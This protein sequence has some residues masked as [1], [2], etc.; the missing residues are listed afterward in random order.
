MIIAVV[1]LAV[2][3]LFICMT[4]IKPAKLRITLSLLCA[5]VVIAS[6]VL[7]VKNDRE[8]FGLQRVSQT[9]TYS[10]VSTASSAN[11]SM[12]LYKTIGT[13]GKEK[14]YLYKTSDRPK[15]M[16][17]TDPDPGKS[18]VKVVQNKT[19]SAQMKVVTTRWEYRNQEAK[20]WFG[21]AGNDHKLINRHYTFSVGSNWFVLS[22]TQAQALQKELKQNQA[23]LEAAAKT[24]VAQQVKAKLT[25]ALAKNPTMTASQRQTL[26]QQ[27]AKEAAAAYQQQAL[28]QAVQQIKQQTK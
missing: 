27:L 25:A 21:I 8:H 23:Q 18:R 4:A 26:S 22:T 2:L 9:K 6:M 24:Y 14:T 3:L 15:K 28:A 16:Q 7:M 19:N 5:L 1:I 10:L 20:F 12:L 13:A 11:T 17:H